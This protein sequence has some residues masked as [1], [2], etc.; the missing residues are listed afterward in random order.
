MEGVL[1]TASGDGVGPSLL[2]SVRSRSDKADAQYLFNVPEGF[3]RFALEHRI[4]PGLQLRACFVSDLANATGLPGLLMRL[5]GEGHG[6]VEVLG[7]RGVRDF[8]ISLR[9]FV[10]W[11]YPAV[12][13]SE[14]GYY[15]R[16]QCRKE[17]YEDEFLTVLGVWDE[18]NN[19]CPT[20]DRKFT[21]DVRLP[22]WMRASKSSLSRHAN[23]TPSKMN[24]VI[25]SSEDAVASSGCCSKDSA[26]D[27]LRPPQG[28]RPETFDDVEEKSSSDSSSDACSCTTSSSDSYCEDSSSCSLSEEA[29]AKGHE[30]KA[31]DHIPYNGDNKSQEHKK[32]VELWE[33]RG[34][35]YK[36]VEAPRINVF[37]RHCSKVQ[38]TTASPTL[39]QGHNPTSSALLG[40]VCYLKDLNKILF[41][42]STRTSDACERLLTHPVLC[43]L[44]KEIPER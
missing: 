37:E 25:S 28:N 12:M 41:V 31:P 24:E 15:S 21:R 18:E 9:H 3:S 43:A 42:A 4:R 27:T 17:L 36:S 29:L 35:L 10:H 1:V 13:V 6:A 38:K 23:G 39:C 30:T 11:K 33:L 14:F 7:P 26:N 8:V 44:Q 34:Q 40:F 2:L 22:T 5:R 19:R 32:P 20:C 16:V